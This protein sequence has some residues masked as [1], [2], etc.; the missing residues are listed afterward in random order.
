M[1]SILLLLCFS[2]LAGCATMK[3]SFR[4]KE[5]YT[6]GDKAFYAFAVGTQVIDYDSSKDAYSRGCIETSPIYGEHPS[7]VALIAGK[8]VSVSLITWVSNNIRNHAFRKWWLGS[9]GLLAGGASLHNY[10]LD[11]GQQAVEDN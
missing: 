3:D 11:C 2:M 4:V 7:D 8:L 10:N 1:K 5:P 9:M 6:T